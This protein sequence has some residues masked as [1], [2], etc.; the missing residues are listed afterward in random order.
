MIVYNITMK[1][2]PGIETAWLLWQKKEHIPEIM[3]S[4]YFSDAKFF[5]LLEQEETEGI[6]YVVQYTA[7][8][9]DQYHNYIKEFAS[10]LREKAFTKWGDKFIAFRTIMEIVN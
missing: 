2:D 5:R 6:T 9:L 7:P 10:G 1:V 3:S 4:G 8:T